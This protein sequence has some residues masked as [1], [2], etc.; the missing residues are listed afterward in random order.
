MNKAEQFLDVCEAK[1]SS[2]EKAFE[3]DF[4][5]FPLRLDFYLSL[6]ND[7]KPGAVGIRVQGAGS[8]NA[9]H[10]SNFID[11]KIKRSRFIKKISSSER[12]GL[13]WDKTAGIMDTK[14]FKSLLDVFG[15]KIKEKHP[16]MWTAD[17]VSVSS[18]N[19]LQLLIDKM[20]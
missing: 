10:L 12:T 16:G 15:G 18:L 6:V 2:L 14:N 19:D 17:I 7:K 5:V 13:G 20:K 4:K 11:Q 8:T 9:R 3:R 1:Q